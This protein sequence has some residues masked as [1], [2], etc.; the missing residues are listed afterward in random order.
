MARTSIKHI[1][2]QLGISCATVSLALNGK[3]KNSRVS[4]TTVEKVLK[5]ASDL[6]YRPNSAARSLRTGRTKTLGLIVADIS[7]P[8][9]AKLSRNIENIAHE[10]GYQVMFG[11]SDESNIKF[12][13]IVDL[14][15]E[16]NVDG[17]IV[18]PPQNSEKIIVQLVKDKI[19]LILID[20]NIE[21]NIVS[22]IQ[23]D[24]F[25]AGYMLTEHMIKKGCSRIGFIAYNPGLRNIEKRFE[26]YVDALKNNGIGFEEKYVKFVTF[27]KFEDEIECSIDEL[28]SDNVDSVI[29]A[30]NRVGLQSLYYLQK[31][32]KHKQLQYG[33]IDAPDEY[34]IANIPIT[35]VLQP[36]KE[37]SERSLSILFNNMENPTSLI[38]EDVTLNVKLQV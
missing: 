36:I 19:P 32:E 21:G 18:A 7:N 14:F 35:C 17:L 30:T 12:Q 15:I 28:I 3:G 10:K 2:D 31:Q 27:E 25:K 22:S 8:F 38:N 24:N 37:L 11:S 5:M 26:G 1:A 16:K 13:E 29:F 6:N 4:K 34:K 20:R 9:F 23:I 33:S